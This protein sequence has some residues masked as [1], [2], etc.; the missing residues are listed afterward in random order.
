MNSIVILCVLIAAASAI[1]TPRFG[2]VIG[3]IIGGEDAS[4]N[5]FPYMVSV[6]YFGSHLCGGAIIRGDA[7]LTSAHCIVGPLQSMTI[8]AGKHNIREQES[9]EQTRTLTSIHSHEGYPGATGFS[10][11]IAVLRVSVPFVMSSAVA[12]IPIAPPG[13]VAS[14]GAS[15]L[16]WGTLQEDGAYPDVLQKAEVSIV[17]DDAC[18]AAYGAANFEGDKMIC[19]GLPNGGADSCA[20]DSGGPMTAQDRGYRYL[21]GLTSF[22]NGCG[23]PGFPGVYTEVAHYTDF[24]NTHAG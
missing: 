9:T 21:A 11:D 13:H 8:K 17:T 1:P 2:K 6:Q 14:G 7:V 23:R 5:E 4:P 18:L 12:P 10:D 20:G 24:I 15:I 16:G 22:G 3:R 19:A